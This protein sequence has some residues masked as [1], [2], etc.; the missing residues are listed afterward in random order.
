MFLCK[1]NPKAKPQEFPMEE[2]ETTLTS[3]SRDAI[4]IVWLF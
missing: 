4:L 2:L 1:K 3:L